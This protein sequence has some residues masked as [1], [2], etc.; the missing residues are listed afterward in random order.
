MAAAHHSLNL[1]AERY[2][3]ALF[4]LA[5]DDQVLD[6]VAADLDGLTNA[7][8]SHAELGRVVRSPVIS[9]DAQAKAM[10]ALLHAAGAHKLTRNLVLLAAENRRLFLLPAIAKAYGALIAKSRGEIVAE[11]TSAFAL[12]DAQIAELK[13]ALKASYG[14]EPRL[15]VAVDPSLIAGLI[16]KVGSKM[17]DSSIKTKLVRLK[18]ALKEAN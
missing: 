13:A 14:R 4:D 1:A 2:A 3:Q 17:I 9:R 15:A 8:A 11:V 16:V 12:D 5:R 6:L 18:A 10:G 7:I